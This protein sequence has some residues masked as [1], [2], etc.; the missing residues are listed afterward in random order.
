MLTH[1]VVEQQIDQAIAKIEA[2]D[3]IRGSVVRIRVEHF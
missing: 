1:E 2:L 3:A